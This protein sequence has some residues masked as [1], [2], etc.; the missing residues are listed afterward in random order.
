V[1]GEPEKASFAA[2]L[3]AGVDVEED[4]RSGRA[5]LEVPDIACLLDDEQPARAVPGVRDEDRVVEAGA[6]RAKADVDRRRVERDGVRAGRGQS[7]QQRG[8]E[9]ADAEPSAAGVDQR[10]PSALKRKNVNCDQRSLMAVS[11]SR[12]GSASS[13]AAT[14]TSVLSDSTTQPPTAP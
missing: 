4:R 3:G 6:D 10:Q 14:S 11:R 13:T 1:E 7:D 12:K 2:T 5:R 8:E 9:E